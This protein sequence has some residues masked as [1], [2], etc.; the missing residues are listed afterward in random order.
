MRNSDIF[1]NKYDLRL[2]EKVCL[3]TTKEIYIKLKL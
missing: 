3:T 2:E 1:H